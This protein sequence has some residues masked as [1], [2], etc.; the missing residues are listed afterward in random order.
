MKTMKIFLNKICFV[1]ATVLI[2]AMI[3]I[4]GCDTSLGGGDKD[5]KPDP[6]NLS[7]KFKN[8]NN[9]DV[10]FFVKKNLSL[11]KSV[12]AAI[13]PADYFLSGYLEDE[14]TVYELFGYYSPASETYAL[15]AAAG[16]MRYNLYGFYDPAE[17][18]AASG[19][20][21]V[22]SGPDGDW[23]ASLP[24]AVSPLSEAPAIAGSAVDSDNGFPPGMLGNWFS[25]DPRF[26]MVST[27]VNAFSTVYYVLRETGEWTMGVF[28]MFDGPASAFY[29]EVWDEGGGIFGAI[30][31]FPGINFYTKT[32]FKVE[33]GKLFTVMATAG[34]DYEEVKAF[35]P[36]DG[37]TWPE[38]GYTRVSPVN[39]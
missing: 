18:I 14:G 22:L 23:A 6:F 33:G 19:D 30:A 9:E 39:P 34:T 15:S 12:R 36:D 2:A 29:S 17:G 7:G 32:A 26:L 13:G 28:A 5:G 24:I 31:A 11:S 8:E 4:A 20:A 3:T 27:V 16:D 10:E 35:T 1:M 38:F 25:E 21:I 37:Y